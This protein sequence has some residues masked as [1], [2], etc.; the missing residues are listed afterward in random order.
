[1]STQYS[2][3]S[4]TFLVPFSVPAQDDLW[5]PY[6][7]A[8][9][10]PG[11]ELAF[12]GKVTFSYPPSDEIVT[13]WAVADSCAGEE[14]VEAYCRV[15]E[16][17]ED[18]NQSS[19]SI[20]VVDVRGPVIYDV[21][22]DPAPPVQGSPVSILASISDASGVGRVE[23]WY[24]YTPIAGGLAENATVPMEM[25]SG[26]AWQVDLGPFERGELRYGII[27]WDGAGNK[28]E[29]DTFSVRIYSVID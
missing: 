19:V 12:Q 13:L 24:L 7:G 18:N 8:A 27:A 3:S 11:D 2:E 15:L 14:F 23:L 29:T 25:V 20:A 4:G 6:S 16:S 1:V 21:F 22:T 9:L 26:L 28:S 5:Y 17:N 10:A